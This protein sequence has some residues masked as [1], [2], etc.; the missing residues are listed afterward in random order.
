MTHNAT[1]TA[2][3][4]PI[5]PSV[6]PLAKSYEAW[7]TDIWGVVHNGVAAITQ[8]C[9]TLIRYREQGGIVVLISNS[10]RPSGPVREQMAALGVPSDV[11]DDTVTSGDVTRSL[12]QDMAQKKFFHLGPE[13]DRSL[14]DGLP[15]TFVSPE[16]AEI[17]V[18]T[19]LRDDETET[20]EDY[21]KE[22]E[23]FRARHVPLICANPDIFVERGN[24]LVPCAGA[25]AQLYET[26]GGQ[27]I[28]AGKPHRPI[29]ELALAR[30]AKHAGL[31]LPRDRILAIGDGVKTDMAGACAMELD[32]LFIAS[33]V[34]LPAETGQNALNPETL[35]HLFSD[36]PCAPIGAQ[37]QLTW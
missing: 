24:R 12:L 22:L 18:L 1:D 16:D 34:H 11:Y 14:F 37:A 20:A 25:L 30:I 19:G 32:A 15:L 4:I 26:L 3:P 23:T 6:A 21:R 36:A 2:N 31:P 8:A 9:T 7:L 13:R 27:V 17:V 33:G 5:L 35:T 29:Y 28:Y 10:P